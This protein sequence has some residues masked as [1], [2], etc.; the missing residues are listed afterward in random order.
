MSTLWQRFRRLW[1][2][3][4]IRLPV[5]GLRPEALHPGDRL[6]I[7]SRLWRVESRRAAPPAAVFELATAEGPP[8]RADLRC[9]EGRWSLTSG[10]GVPSPA[11][12]LDPAGVIHFPVAAPTVTRR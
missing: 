8:G 10:A 3:P 9:R 5:P 4:R 2:E 12:E 1:R 7:G 6:Q 11:I